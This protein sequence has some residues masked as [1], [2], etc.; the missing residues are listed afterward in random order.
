MQSILAFCS[1]IISCMKSVYQMSGE[2]IKPIH[3][4]LFRACLLIVA[5]VMF[6]YC[7]EVWKDTRSWLDLP[8]I[9]EWYFGT[10]EEFFIAALITFLVIG[11]IAWFRVEDFCEYSL[12]DDNFVI[13]QRQ[14]K[15]ARFF[16]AM[17]LLFIADVLYMVFRWTPVAVNAVMTWIS[18]W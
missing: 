3:V 6:R 4:F 13:Y 2:G 1:A 7:M 8:M 5:P 16:I 17:V 15:W 11:S 9:P 14:K 12:V 18:N 10:A